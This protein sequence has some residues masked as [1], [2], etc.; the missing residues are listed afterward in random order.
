MLFIATLSL[1]G[2]ISSDSGQDF[3]ILG[4]HDLSSTASTST[5]CGNDEAGLG[6]LNCVRG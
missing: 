4:S 2:L 3:R 5:K 1:M 6:G